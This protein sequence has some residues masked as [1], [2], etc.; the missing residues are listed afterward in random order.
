MPILPVHLVQELNVV[1]VDVELIPVLNRT[2][3]QEQ[4][5]YVYTLNPTWLLAKSLYFAPPIWE[6]NYN[7]MTTCKTIGILHRA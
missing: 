3:E 4:T 6:S 1:T 7:H 2:Q 5:Q